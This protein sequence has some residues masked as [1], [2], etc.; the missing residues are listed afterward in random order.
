MELLDTMNNGLLNTLE[1]GDEAAD[2][3]DAA[4]LGSFTEMERNHRFANEVRH[5]LLA[6]APS[7]P[8]GL[9]LVDTRTCA[10]SRTTTT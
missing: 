7:E 4:G 5:Q 1:E 2:D 9:H 6:I 3:Y 10:R 8:N